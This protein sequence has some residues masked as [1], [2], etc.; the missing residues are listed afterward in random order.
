MQRTNHKLGKQNLVT[1]KDIH[2]F[3]DEYKCALCDIRG[4]RYGVSSFLMVDGRLSVS[5]IHSCPKA[6]L[7]ERIRITMCDAFGD[8]FANITPDSVHD[9]VPAPK[10][11]NNKGGVWVMGSGEPVKVLFG[12][13]T[14]EEE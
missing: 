5:K 1:L 12:E 4:K 9:V 14:T 13:F 6:E 10:G 2:G 8:H 7:P 3:Y 11:Q